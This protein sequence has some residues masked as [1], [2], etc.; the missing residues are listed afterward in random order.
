MTGSMTTAGHCSMAWIPRSNSAPLIPPAGSFT[1]SSANRLTEP[2][3]ITHRFRR[4][5][6][7]KGCAHAEKTG[8]RGQT[9][10]DL[11]ITALGRCFCALRFRNSGKLYVPEKCDAF[12]R[13]AG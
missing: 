5:G 10:T 12:W 8:I 1:A 7:E 2:G 11:R 3:Q 6:K 9:K 4:R 13:E